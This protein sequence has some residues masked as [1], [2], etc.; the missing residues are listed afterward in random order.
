[1]ANYPQELAQD[2]VCQIHTGHT[3]GLC[4]LPAR[5]LRLNT[6]E[7]T[8]AF[9]RR[10]APRIYCLS[11]SNPNLWHFSSVLIRCIYRNVVTGVI[12]FII[13]Q[14]E[15]RL[16]SNKPKYVATSL[17]SGKNEL[18]SLWHVSHRITEFPNKEMS[19][20]KNVKLHTIYML[21]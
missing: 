2:S 17:L 13:R 11:F 14:L 5:P 6:N 21:L 15:S 10:P 4:F 8:N 1:M 16:L 12:L 3:T 7:W 20:K 9:I 19:Q 18:G